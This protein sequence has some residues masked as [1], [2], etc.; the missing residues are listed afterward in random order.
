MS[1]TV[2]PVVG[3]SPPVGQ[4]VKSVMDISTICQRFVHGRGRGRPGPR[5]RLRAVDRHAAGDPCQIPRWMAL[6]ETAVARVGQSLSNAAAG[7]HSTTIRPRMGL[8]R[9]SSSRAGDRAVP[10]V[11][12]RRHLAKTD[13]R[14]GPAHCRPYFPLIDPRAAPTSKMPAGAGSGHESGRGGGLRTPRPCSDL[15]IRPSAARGTSSWLHSNVRNA[16]GDS[17]RAH[18]PGAWTRTIATAAI[19]PV[20]ES[21]RPAGAPPA[22]APIQALEGIMASTPATWRN[23]RRSTAWPRPRGS[24]SCS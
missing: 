22:V 13:A 9:A 24:C 19:P 14:R 15:N 12:G 11:L 20:G 4:C 3:I 18:R 7:K 10:S 16:G 5:C 2:V 1:G 6:F 21:K 8:R 17:T 23:W